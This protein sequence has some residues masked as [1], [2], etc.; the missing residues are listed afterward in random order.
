MEEPDFSYHI[1]YQF[2][3]CISGHHE[4]LYYPFN[5]TPWV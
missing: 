2:P 5:I 4:A 1:A 3:N